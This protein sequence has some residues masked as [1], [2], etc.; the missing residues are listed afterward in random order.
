MANVFGGIDPNQFP[1]QF[2]DELEPHRYETLT[3]GQWLGLGNHFDKFKDE[4][5]N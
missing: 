3:E 4:A 1:I 5:C 2:S